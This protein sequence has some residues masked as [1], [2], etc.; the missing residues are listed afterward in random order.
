MH[1]NAPKHKKL[2]RIHEAHKGIEKCPLN[3]RK[4]V[5]WRGLSRDIE[6]SVRTC[7]ICRE[8]LRKNSTKTMLIKK[9][10]IRPFQNIAAEIFEFNC[11]EFLLFADQ[12]SKMLSIKIV[13]REDTY[14]WIKARKSMPCLSSS[15]KYVHF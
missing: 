8:H 14:S 6:N 15:K 5:Y 7:E 10:A 9:Q 13:A 12:Y 3:A 1:C 4:S 11:Q 2:K